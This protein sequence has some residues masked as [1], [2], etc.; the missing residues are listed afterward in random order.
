MISKRRI[1]KNKVPDGFSRIFDSEKTVT[2]NLLDNFIANGSR[3]EELIKEIT[4][5]CKL[6]EISVDSILS[7]AFLISLLIEI[8][9]S[10][11]YKRSKILIV[12]WF[13]DNEK[14][15]SPCI[16]YIKCLYKKTEN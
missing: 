8:P 15:I 2:R 10:R 4:G 11:N 1:R 3:G 6:N 9:I 14:R 16:E 13:N 5:C 7:I 12:K